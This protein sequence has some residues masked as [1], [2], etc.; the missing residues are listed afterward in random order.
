MEKLSIC[1]TEGSIESWKEL[2][3]YLISLGCV[4]GLSWGYGNFLAIETGVKSPIDKPTAWITSLETRS[5]G[6][7]VTPTEAIR[8]VKEFLNIKEEKMETKYKKG[9]Y[10]VFLTAYS[11]TQYPIKKGDIRRVSSEVG[12]STCR[13][14]YF[15]IEG[16]PVSNW[17]H[18]QM[19][20][21]HRLATL[22]EIIQYEV[23]KALEKLNNKDTQTV[24]FG[25]TKSSKA[26]DPY[27]S[28]EEAKNRFGIII[29]NKY[30]ASWHGLPAT[31]HTV[32]AVE[33][34]GD[35]HIVAITDQSRMGISLYHN[36]KWLDDRKFVPFVEEN[37]PVFKIGDWVVSNYGGTKPEAW[38]VSS[39][40]STNTALFWYIEHANK[41]GLRLATPKEIEE[42]LISEAKNKGIEIGKSISFEGQH[43]LGELVIKNITQIRYSDWSKSLLVTEDAGS[44]FTMFDGSKWAKDIKPYVAPKQFFFGKS[45]V[46]FNV[47][48]GVDVSMMVGD[49]VKAIAYSNAKKLKEHVE[50]IRN[51]TLGG[52]KIT[53]QTTEKQMSEKILTFGCQSG[54]YGEYLAIMEECEKLLNNK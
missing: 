21:S 31:C 4:D 1:V 11:F 26:T 44:T 17:S 9:D 48:K 49:A 20:N 29:G 7:I 45:P 10:I 25:Q 22:E 41:Y 18:D 47:V 27:V 32:K 13:E 14:K 30:M 12:D 8:L 6:K 35:G 38:L 36:R 37:K 16:N 19:N 28:I 50:A 43:Y 23:K 3:K 5:F 51:F 39:D 54:S 33:F 2:G 24:D 52:Y 40:E 46:S 42:K 34:Q 53:N 15:M